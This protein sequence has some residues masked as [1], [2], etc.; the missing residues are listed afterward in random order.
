MLGESMHTRT[1]FDDKRAAISKLGS[2]KLQGQGNEAKT[3]LKSSQ[4]ISIVKL[5]NKD[6]H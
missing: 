6:Y 1:S 3:T 4:Y 5:P 2:H